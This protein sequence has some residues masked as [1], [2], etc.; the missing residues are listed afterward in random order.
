MK[1]KEMIKPRMLLE[2]RHSSQILLTMA[3][4]RNNFKEEEEDLSWVL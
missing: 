4:I 3:R 1:Y 2:G